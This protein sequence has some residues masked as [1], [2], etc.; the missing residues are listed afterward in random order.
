MSKCLLNGK[1]VED[2][3][4]D[5]VKHKFIGTFRKPLSQIATPA[6]CP[7]GEMIAY[8]DSGIVERSKFKHWQL[9]HFDLPQYI[10]IV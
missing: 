2:E 1:E 10:D 6:N 8:Y 9:G 5:P 7:C 4:I 3:V